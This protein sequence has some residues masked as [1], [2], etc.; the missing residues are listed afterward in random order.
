MAMIFFKKIQANCA[1]SIFPT[2]ASTCA[3]GLLR[4]TS[5][6]RGW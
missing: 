6:S 5:W 4:G 2:T 3:Q 1:N